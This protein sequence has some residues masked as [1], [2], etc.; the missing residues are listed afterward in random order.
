MGSYFAVDEDIEEAALDEAQSLA[1]ILQ[2]KS[3]CEDENIPSVSKESIEASASKAPEEEFMII[4][5]EDD[6]N[7][8]ATSS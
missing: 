8:S 3:Q 7:I 2:L 4:K 5:E 6:E 1:E